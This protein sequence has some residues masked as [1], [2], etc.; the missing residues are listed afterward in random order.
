ME[1]RPPAKKKESRL[2]SLVPQ[3][4]RACS[5]QTGAI[6]YGSYNYGRNPF[7]KVNSVQLAERKRKLPRLKEDVRIQ[8]MAERANAEWA[9]AKKLRDH[10][11]CHLPGDKG[12]KERIRH[13]KAQIKLSQ[14][15]S[16]VKKKERARSP[17]LS[18]TEDDDKP[19]SLS[20]KFDGHVHQL[21]NT[22]MDLHLPDEDL[23]L[24]STVRNVEQ[25]AN[26]YKERT[27]MSGMRLNEEDFSFVSLDQYRSLHREF[28]RLDVDGRFM[29]A[30]NAG[31]SVIF[32]GMLVS[33]QHVKKALNSK[34]EVVFAKLIRQL[35]PT[36]PAQFF[37]RLEEQFRREEG[38][39]REKT[40]DF[41]ERYDLSTVRDIE[42]C[43]NSMLAKYSRQE[44][45]SKRTRDR[46]LTLEEFLRYSSTIRTMS[47]DE[48]ARTFALASV[49]AL[50]PTVQRLLTVDGFAH[51]V[52]T[53]L[54]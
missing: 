43:F 35:M 48:A 25:R 16:V 45:I 44:R 42:R 50:D 4:P 22:V 46:G 41:R 38:E 20:Q 40:E 54:L 1:P 13:H 6:V 7:K 10:V 15:K 24:Q 12:N 9:V 53:D 28:E 33:A 14:Q 30:L 5:R 34:L 19:S 27:T 26:T 23:T 39:R 18:A 47:D 32:V 52:K 17:Q 11:I 36:V 21:E 37:D 3:P 49:E 51:L 29:D 31:D 8:E 2:P